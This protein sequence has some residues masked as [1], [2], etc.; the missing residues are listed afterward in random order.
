M[1]IYIHA[2]L[3]MPP[4]LASPGDA[5]SNRLSIEKRAMQQDVLSMSSPQVKADKPASETASEPASEPAS[6]SR[7]HTITDHS[8]SSSHAANSNLVRKAAGLTLAEA[9]QRIKPA[10]N[11]LKP[12][13]TI[14]I[15]YYKET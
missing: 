7:R 5:S 6:A 13:L 14:V 8:D 2:I 10:G 15:Q 12:I 11:A 3:A 9:T 4:K 1:Q